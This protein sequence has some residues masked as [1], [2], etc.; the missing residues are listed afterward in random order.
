MR[1]LLPALLMLA[2]APVLAEPVVSA[3]PEAV[4]VSIYRNP[5][6]GPDDPI[7]LDYLGGFA[8]ITETRTVELPPGRVTV[9]FEG[10]A[11]GILPESAILLGTGVGEKNQDRRL[12][13]Q[14]GLLDA[15]TGQRVTLKRTDP[16]TGKVTEESATVRS[17]A[18]GVVVQTAAGFEALYCTGLD[19]TLV[20]PSVPPD[21]SARPTLSVLTADQPGGRQTLTL[22]YLASNFDWQANYVA[23]LSPDA[24]RVDLFA[25]L[26]MASADSTSF[27]E[28]QANAVAGR[29][30]REESQ[31][32]EL[33][34]E[35]DEPIR[36]NCWPAGTTTSTLRPPPP[37]PPPAPPPPMMMEM[38]MPVAAI[39]EDD[40]AIAVTGTRIARREELGDLKL[41]RIPMPVTVAAN[42]QKQVA[43]LDK[44]EVKGELLYR[45]Q[46]YGSDVD[47]DVGL[48]YR[49]LNRPEAG[50]G[51]PLPGG[52]VALFQQAGGRR[53]LVGEARLDDKAVG[54]EVE[55][56]FGEADNVTL[57]TEERDSGD[58]WERVR[59]I[60]RN[61]NPHAILF[62]GEFPTSG[63]YRYDRFG[64]RVVRKPGKT[65]WRAS[66]PANRE[67]SFDYRA[68]EIDRD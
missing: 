47:T 54:E 35:G 7:E 58:G 63:D 64:G 37:P 67:I 52:Q 41:Y 19:Q 26:T 46:L 25:W 48:L 56:V 53:G 8:L 36:Y 10:V 21:L 57:E 24:R 16:A 68:V 66:V 59:L 12:L 38:A 2:P 13:S 9:R 1:L 18:N 33:M 14:R 5:S 62:E 4:S 17:G 27:V 45:A 39:S 31:A 49:I 11:S 42:S 28:A 65:V 40:M 32:P 34:D 55:L 3:G 20:F 30:A 23:E 51:E 60:V 6:R 44:K 22:A 43:F 61:A 50:L 15:F 29:V